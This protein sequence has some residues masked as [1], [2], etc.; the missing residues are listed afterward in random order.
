M[1]YEI[2][3]KKG[4]TADIGSALFFILQVKFMRGTCKSESRLYSDVDS[5]AFMRCD[6]V[7]HDSGI[8]TLKT[9]EQCCHGLSVL[10]QGFF[11]CGDADRLMY[12]A[13]TLLHT[14]VDF[15]GITSQIMIIKKL[16]HAQVTT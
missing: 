12:A 1:I 9:L 11:Q 16:Y 8:C 5:S 4:C 2:D 6:G 15:H 10:A 14:V 13:E 3:N 7:F